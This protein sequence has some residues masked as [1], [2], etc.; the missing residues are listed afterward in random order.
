MLF[1]SAVLACC[2]SEIERVAVGAAIREVH[3]PRRLELV[4]EL[5]RDPRYL[6]FSAEAEWARVHLAE[7][8]PAGSGKTFPLLPFARKHL[9]GTRVGAATQVGFDRILRL[10]IDHRGGAIALD[11]VCT[12]LIEIM[13]K[14]SNILLLNNVDQVLE[15]AKHVTTDVSRARAILPHKDYTSPPTAGGLDPR[16]ARPSDFEEVLAG[17]PLVWP[18]ALSR[19][20]EGLSPFLLEE[21]ATRAEV[22]GDQAGAD[23]GPAAMARLLDALE[24][25]L[26]DLREQ[27]W[28]AVAFP[29]DRGEAHYP[30]P[31]HP[32]LARG[33]LQPVDLLSLTIER[34]VEEGRNRVHLQALRAEVTSGVRRLAR[35]LEERA[36]ALEAEASPEVA[37]RVRR[38]A[39][40]LAASFHLLESGMDR[41][42]VPDPYMPEGP[43]LA[44]PLDPTRG[45]A[46]NMTRLFDRARRLGEGA[47]RAPERLARTEADLERLRRLVEAAEAATSE[48]EL[49]RLR[50]EA[51][52]MGV[53]F[54]GE[55][56]AAGREGGPGFPSRLSS[57]GFEIV[58]GRSAEESDALLRSVAAP[59]DWWLHARDHRG[60]HVIVRSSKHPDRVPRNTLIEAARLAA[61]L[62]KARHSSLVPVDYTLRKYVRKARKGPSGL[63]IF[64]REKT[65]MVEPLSDA[66]EAF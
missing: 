60:G 3:Q 4:L 18:K 51:A 5:D 12:V 19:H 10:S 20:Y 38:Q 61:F 47:R 48:G 7:R 25:I 44:I 28:H 62:S 22:A 56:E 37:A 59:D 40:A 14:H 24:G 8:V 52:R 34:H 36:E 17:S 46:E 66:D 33:P 58:Y 21:V 29:S 65:L 42:E 49:A 50:A 54:R 39:E 63:H 27:R 9:R 53:R 41:V 43:P 1:D 26:S 6:V 64:E 45:P 32:P 55:S 30:V 57:D 31:V 2:R 11:P 15:A 35:R 16:G 13:G 23:L